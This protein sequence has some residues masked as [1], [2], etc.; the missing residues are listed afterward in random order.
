M[1]AL[2][3]LRINDLRPLV[4]VGN[5]RQPWG[6]EALW[7][8]AAGEHREGCVMLVKAPAGQ[9]ETELG[10]P[11]LWDEPESA[12]ALQREFAELSDDL[13]LFDRLESRVDDVD[14][15]A[16]LAR[17]EPGTEWL[18][19]VGAD[20]AAGLPTWHEAETLRRTHRFV[21]VT[22]PGVTAPIPEG[23]DCQVVEIPPLDI[24]STGLRAM[25]AA[26]RSIR[27]LTPEPVARLLQAWQ[28]YRS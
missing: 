16:E 6:F 23:W 14:T 12:Q 20:A 27:H 18:V 22:R 1:S 17:R 10:R 25:V 5:A 7:E 26:G 24:S 9:L 19:V 28:L 3:Q 15:L 8:D 13:D 4:T 21:V 2:A 11:D